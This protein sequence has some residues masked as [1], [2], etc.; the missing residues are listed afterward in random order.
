[1]K[2]ITIANR[3]GG[4]GKTTCAYN[5]AWTYAIQKKKVCLVDLDS[6]ANLSMLCNVDPISLDEFKKAELYEINEYLDILPGTKAIPMLENEIQQMFD[7]YS[8]VKDSMLPKLKGYDYIIFDTSPSLSILNINAFMVSDYVHVIINPDTFSY[9]GL[10]EMKEIIEQVQT[11]NTKLK[12]DIVLNGHTKNRKLTGSLDSNLEQD[13]AFSGVVIPERQHIIDSIARNKP[14]I[15]M[16]EI[17]EP[18]FKLAA[19]A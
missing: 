7:R 19:I 2:I 11:K 12:F 6:Q 15:D 17:K 4:V 16:Q 13:T 14:A 5:L 18:F 1:M 10:V 9:T 8:F 3:K